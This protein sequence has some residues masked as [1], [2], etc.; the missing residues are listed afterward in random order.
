M[1]DEDDK[2]YGLFNENETMKLLKYL[3][4]NKENIIKEVEEENKV[5]II[6]EMNIQEEEKKEERKIKSKFKN[7]E[8]SESYNSNS[9]NEDTNSNKKKS[10]S[11][12]FKQSKNILSPSKIDIR[13]IKTESDNKENI[14]SDSSYLNNNNDDLENSFLPQSV[15][16]QARINKFKMN[17]KLI[18]SF[19]TP[20]KD[21]LNEFKTPNK[22]N[23]SIQI[24]SKSSSKE[25]INNNKIL[26]PRISSAKNLKKNKSK[27]FL[28]KTD[29]E[30]KLINP[31]KKKKITSIPFNNN[32]QK[33]FLSSKSKPKFLDILKKKKNDEII[34][35]EIINIEKENL[36]LI[37]EL[38][39]LNLQLN[40][41]INKQNHNNISI[42]NNKNYKS[43]QPIQHENLEQSELIIRKKYLTNLISEYN[44]L[45]DKFNMENENNIIIQLENEIKEKT[46]EY[47]KCFKENKLLKE[48]IYNNNNYL[49]NNKY[50][51]NDNLNSKS[52]LYMKKILNKKNEIE[53]MKITYKTEY[54]KIISLNEK[55]EKYNGI[56]NKYETI[57]KNNN[58]IKTKEKDKK[59]EEEIYKL[60]K[61]KAILVQSRN[62]MKNNYS[63]EINKQRKYIEQLKK[64]IFEVNKL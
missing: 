25:K 14:F 55:Y 48:K 58:E 53:Q 50:T 33:I 37:K 29:S 18:N 45:Y 59:L 62:S 9:E 10:V 64:S 42:Y 20:P 35:N 44:R 7:K 38:E 12:T 56:L 21:N 61:K 30:D 46:N 36:D 19:N 5:S 27:L 11:F 22:V 28:M 4:N 32:K 16:S 15:I 40:T 47:K 26:L 43:V 41:L 49:K 17:N 54:K 39:K 1:D 2:S 8:K 31:N 52:E 23:K 13:S 34:D 3:K 63:N 60:S 6:N 24:F 57:Y 51:K